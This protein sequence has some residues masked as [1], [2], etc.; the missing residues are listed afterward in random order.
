VGINKEND[1]PMRGGKK[2]FN[3]EINQPKCITPKVE[4]RKKRSGVN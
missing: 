3:W 4:G 1:I 2:R